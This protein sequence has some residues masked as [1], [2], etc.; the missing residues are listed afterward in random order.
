MG[1]WVT[2]YFNNVYQRAWSN[3]FC[4]KHDYSVLPKQ[5]D[6]NDN[7]IP[8]GKHFASQPKLL[9]FSQ[10]FS[11]SDINPDRIS[12][13]KIVSLLSLKANLTKNL[14]LQN[15]S[16]ANT[17]FTHIA[18]PSLSWNNIATTA[19]VLTYITHYLRKKSP[20]TLPWNRVHALSDCSKD[21]LEQH[22]KLFVDF[23]AII[24]SQKASMPASH[25]YSK[26]IC[27]YE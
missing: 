27:L 17:P 12:S 19:I 10:G 14:L 18:E 26:I 7:F 11:Q 24:Q 9:F 16:A 21:L 22:Q 2:Q 25:P 5:S 20:F 23:E 1:H 4:N 13:T 3:S 6:I 8:V 15:S